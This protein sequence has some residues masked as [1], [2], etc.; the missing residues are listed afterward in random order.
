MRPIPTEI[1]HHPD[2]ALAVVQRPVEGA[3]GFLN[4]HA[5]EIVID[6]DQPE[7]EKWIILFHELLHM[8]EANLLES[9][10][11]RRHVTHDFITHAAPLMFGTLAM[12]G[13]IDG[14]TQQEARAFVRRW[15]EEAGADGDGTEGR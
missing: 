5:G 13:V 15:I 4:A 12:S 10:I 1:T 8:V 14:I 6:P 11:I 2:A 9:G 3:H 7:P